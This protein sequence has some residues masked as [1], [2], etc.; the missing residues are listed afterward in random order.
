LQRAPVILQQQEVFPRLRSLRLQF[1]DP[2]IGTAGV[3]DENLV[4]LAH[5]SSIGRLLRQLALEIG[6][7]HTRSH[8]FA[9]KFSLVCLKPTRRLLQQGQFPAQVLAR[10]F[11]FG[12]AFFEQVVFAAQ[13]LV[14]AAKFCERIAQTEIICLLLLERAQRRADWLDE[15]PE[16]FFEIIERADATV[17]VDQKVAQLLVVF[18]DPG[19]NIGKGRLAA[20][21]GAAR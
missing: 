11:Q 21:F 18:T 20:L 15:V 10:G 12:R 9:G 19:A 4:G 13:V 5:R 17:G 3:I 8:A 1:H 7:L 14:T 6:D 2:L 16:S